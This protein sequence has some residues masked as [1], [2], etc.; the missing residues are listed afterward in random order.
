MSDVA[1]PATYR[2]TGSIVVLSNTG[3]L[4]NRYDVD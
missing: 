1:E 2:T 3:Q 4:E